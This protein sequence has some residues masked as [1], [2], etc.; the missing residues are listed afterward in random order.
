MNTEVLK[1]INEHSEQTATVLKSLGDQTNENQAEIDA[2]KQMVAGANHDV[3]RPQKSFMTQVNKSAQLE[4]LKSGLSKSAN[5]PLQN[6]SVKTLVNDANPLNTHFDTPAHR[7]NEI[8]SDARRKLSLLDVLPSLPVTAGSFEFMQ[9]DGYVNAA[10]YQEKQGDKK[11]AQ[12][13]DAKLQTANIATIAI[14]QKVAEQTLADSVLLGQFLHSR[15]VHNTLSKL[16]SEII[17]GT[18]G[19]GKITGLKAQAT[20]FTPTATA[21]PDQLGEAAAQLEVAGWEAGLII[22]HPTVWNTIRAERSTD[23]V[24]IAGG[25]NNPDQPNVWGVP[26][27]VSASVGVDTALILDPRQVLLLDRQTPAFAF[28]YSSDGFE[29]NVLTAR[30]ELRSGLA[31]LSPSALLKITIS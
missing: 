13:T 25:W 17:G 18:G 8:G 16:E 28:N 26:V 10:D 15:M 23:G 1:A 5:I 7:H 2:L 21:L 29:T 19:T 9:L 24:Y 30:A 4:A 12:N 11:A 31:V 27:V 3:P 20:A 14:T 6:V 22:L